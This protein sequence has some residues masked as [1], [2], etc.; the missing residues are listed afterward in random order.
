VKHWHRLPSEV[1]DASSLETLKVSVDGAL[2]NLIELKDV[3]VH[4]RG[5]LDWMTFKGAFQPKL[6]Y[7]SIVTNSP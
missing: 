6:S 2:S 1:V 4:C 5:G 7:D 3:P